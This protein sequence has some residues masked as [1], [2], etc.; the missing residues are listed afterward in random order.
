MIGSYDLGLPG[1]NVRMVPIDG[2]YS[3]RILIGAVGA[4]LILTILWEAFET[5]VLPR[6][7]TRRFRITRAFYRLTWI[8]YAEVAKHLT[9]PKT[10]ERFLGYFGPLSLLMLLI[11]WALALITGF[12]MFQWSIGPGLQ[13]GSERG[14]FWISVYMSASTF[15]TLGLGDVTPVTGA[16]RAITVSEASTG[17]GFLA[18]IISYLPVLY[19]AFSRREVNIS[20]FDA[21]AGSPPSAGALLSRYAEADNIAEIISLLSEWEKWAADLMESHLSYPV[22]GYYRSQH[23]NQSW[24]SALTTI[25]DTCALIIVGI[26]GLPD[27]QAKLTFA[28]ARHVAVDLS[29]VFRISPA[30]PAER[31][32]ADD[33]GALRQSLAAVGLVLSDGGGAYERLTHLRQMYEPYV[34]SLAGFLLMP[35]PPWLPGPKHADNWQTSIWEPGCR[36]LAEKEM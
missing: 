18:L 4:I 27:W 15:C 36:G 22:L 3:V 11:V 13:L 34:N 8:P 19:Q 6:R 16:A 5:I 21:R 31:L 33:V 28:M 32:A 24:I 30:P 7:V 10:R 1:M 9:S 20:L 14:G 17:F 29:Q 25:L 12:A 35:L 23:D 2:V 26:D